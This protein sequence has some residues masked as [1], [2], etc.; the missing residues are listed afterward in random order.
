[1]TTEMEGIA[2]VVSNGLKERPMPEIL[3]I[4]GRAKALVEL[5]AFIR[6][7]WETTKDT[8]IERIKEYEHE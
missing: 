3:N 7:K 4:C 6:G 5:N 1:M 2:K 8:L